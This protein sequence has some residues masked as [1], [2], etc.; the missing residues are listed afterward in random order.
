M[1]RAFQVLSLCV[2]VAVNASSEDVKGQIA[3][4]G[5]ILETPCAIAMESADQSIDLGTVPLS[6]LKQWG[7]GPRHPFTIHLIDCRLASRTGEALKTFAMTF[8]GPTDNV[9]FLVYGQAAG[10]SLVLDNQDGERVN[11]RVPLNRVRLFLGDRQLKYGLRVVSNHTAYSP[12][13][14]QTTLRFKLDYY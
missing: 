13:N 4:A 7:Q 12:G 14:F 8:D 11:P 6:V 3:M 5:S 9:G 1:K 2:G 10:V